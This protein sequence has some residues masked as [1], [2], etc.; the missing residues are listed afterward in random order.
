MTELQKIMSKR[1][2]QPL[3][4]Y[5]MART[6]GKTTIFPFQEQMLKDLGNKEIEKIVIKKGRENNPSTISLTNRSPYDNKITEKG[7]DVMSTLRTKIVSAMVEKKK[8]IL[9]D[10]LEH[11]LGKDFQTQDLTDRCQ[12]IIRLD[13]VDEF[14][15]DGE[16]MIE[17]YKPSFKHKGTSMDAWQ[18]YRELYKGEKSE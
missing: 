15:I 10:A 6:P 2:K 13:G 4:K 16:V 18:G 9:K 11:K 3:L 12:R 5:V 17:F 1:C 14:V 8:K 7:F